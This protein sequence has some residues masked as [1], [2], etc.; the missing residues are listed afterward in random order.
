MRRSK[1]DLAPLE[2]SFTTGRG[3]PLGASNLIKRLLSI[4]GASILVVFGLSQPAQ[5]TVISFD[6]PITPGA[7][8]TTDIEPGFLAS[9]RAPNQ[10]P[11]APNP[12]AFLTQGYT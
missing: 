11:G 10:F 6:Q 1:E 12:D 8:A 5:A 4:T 3:L 7:N 2:P 9:Y